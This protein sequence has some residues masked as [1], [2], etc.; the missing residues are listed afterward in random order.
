MTFIFSSI[1]FPS[2]ATTYDDSLTN[3]A[4]FPYLFPG[5]VDGLAI[6][7]NG[8]CGLLND[9]SSNRGLIRD[10]E[11]GR[12]MILDSGE[13]LTS[14]SC[15]ESSRKIRRRSENCNFCPNLKIE[16]VMD[17]PKNEQKV[18]EKRFFKVR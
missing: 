5:G 4:R 14:Y 17:E 2:I 8:N 9:C 1:S 12:R 13:T 11:S 18:S 7:S 16:L 15:H 6:L 10:S 3:R